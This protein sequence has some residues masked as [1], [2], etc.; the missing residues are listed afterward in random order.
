MEIQTLRA[1]EAPDHL[2]APAPHHIARG[3]GDRDHEDEAADRGHE[4]LGADA[5]EK[6]AHQM[7]TFVMLFIQRNPSP[8]MTPAPTSM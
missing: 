4:Q 3:D 8:H 7:V 2:V 1:L 5:G 6:V